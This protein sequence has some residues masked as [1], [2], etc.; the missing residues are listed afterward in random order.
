MGMLHTD[1]ATASLSILLV[2]DA[3]PVRQRLK[4]LMSE[5]PSLRV[6][7][8]AGTVPDA[9]REFDARHPDALVLDLSLPNG[10]GLDVLRHARSAGGHCVVIILTNYALPEFRRSCRDLGADYFFAKSDEFEEAV[11]TLRELAER[12]ISRGGIGGAP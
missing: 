6:I 11:Q 3:L 1:S 9:V 7:G 8:E 2:D 10:C 4:A 12:A 5:V